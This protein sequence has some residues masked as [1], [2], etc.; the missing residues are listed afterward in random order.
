M[1]TPITIPFSRYQQL[2]WELSYALDKT[3]KDEIKRWA[4]C[5][6]L[7]F[8]KVTFG[9]AKN[10]A[11]VLGITAKGT[12]LES[13]NF[14]K[15]CLERRLFPH[16]K[17]RTIDLSLFTLE[18]FQTIRELSKNIKKMVIKKPKKT[19]IQMFLAVMGF[20]VGGGGLDGDGGIPDLDLLIS[21]GHHR[22]IV[23]HSVLPMIIIE[24]VCISFIGLVNIVHN[25]LPPGHDPLWDDIK[26]NNE[27][28]LESF[29]TGMSLGL[30][31]HLGIDG[32]IQGD[33]TYKDLPFTMPKFGHQLIAGV[34][35]IT[36]LLYTTKSKVF[37][38]SHPPTKIN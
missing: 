38:K 27:S 35:S 22:S 5:T 31:Y 18:S 23:T 19:G 29:Y 24:G 28:L 9:R 1:N 30:A 12:A 34:N 8:P 17:Q 11:G 7:V 3:E 21:I 13:K 6:A 26:C 4:K 16:A 37:K 25:N 33:G 2:K 32:T 20:N 14:I 36:E 15:A 10:I